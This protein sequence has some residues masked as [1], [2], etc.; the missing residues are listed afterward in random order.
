MDTKRAM[1][2]VSG[3]LYE[4]PQSEVIEMKINGIVCQS[5][6]GSNDDYEN[7]GNV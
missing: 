5:G 7:G 4:T 3:F 1:K 2:K 6:G